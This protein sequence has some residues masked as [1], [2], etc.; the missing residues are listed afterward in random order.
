MYRTSLQQ[1]LFFRRD[2]QTANKYGKLVVFNFIKLCL[3]PHP[4]ILKLLTWYGYEIVLCH[5]LDLTMTQ[6]F[7]HGHTL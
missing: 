3:C 4:D 2:F 1:K 7:V 6:I 5:S